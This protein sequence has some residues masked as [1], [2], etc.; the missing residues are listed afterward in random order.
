MGNYRPISIL[1]VIAKLRE[2][3]I[4]NQVYTYL[5]V[6]N[7]ID[8][9][10]SGFRPMHSTSTALLNVTEDWLDSMDN[11]E[12]IG[13]VTIDL[14]KAFDTVDHTILLDK[15]RLI[16]LDQQSCNWFKSYLSDRM[17]YTVVNCVY[18]SL[19]TITCGVPQ[20]SNL[21]PLLFV[22]YV[23]P[24]SDDPAIGVVLDR[25]PCQLK[26]KRIKHGK[27]INA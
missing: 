23:H 25:I 1:P 14:K 7:I 2:K 18:S 12:I 3:I 20:G 11:G 9:N 22:I 27:F 15:L 6:N 24:Y 16:G 5:S 13:M 17:Q 8:E 21:G 19:L 4:F 10:Q 26:Y